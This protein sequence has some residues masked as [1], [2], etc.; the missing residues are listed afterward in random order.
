MGILCCA[1]TQGTTIHG[2]GRDKMK[3]LIVLLAACFVFADGFRLTAKMLN[4]GSRATVDM[5]AIEIS[6]CAGARCILTRGQKAN[7]A[8]PFTPST[9]VTQL[10][11]KVHGMIA[12]IPIPFPLPEGETDAYKY[13]NCP[14]ERHEPATYKY[15]LFVDPSFPALSV[16]VKWELVDQ[17]GAV[18]VCIIFPATLK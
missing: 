13:T 1:F 18:Q 4:C 17:G 5:K 10:T 11:T 12:G 16:G 7:L 9:Y 2:R 15:S 8:I 6:D 14:I 3:T